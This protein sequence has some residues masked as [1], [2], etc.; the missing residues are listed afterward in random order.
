MNFFVSDCGRFVDF[1]SI[2]PCNIWFK[3]TYKFKDSN[4]DSIVR[5]TPED[6]QRYNSYN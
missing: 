3:F 4:Q 5:V 1:K 2:D 6:I